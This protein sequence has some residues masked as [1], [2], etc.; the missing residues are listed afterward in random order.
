[1]LNKNLLNKWTVMNWGIQ[2]H[3]HL[4]GRGCPL[5]L[6]LLIVILV[7]LLLFLFASLS[8]WSPF[9]SYVLTYPYASV[10]LFPTPF[11]SSQRENL[12]W[13]ISYHPEWYINL[14]GF[15]RKV[16]SWTTGTIRWLPLT[17]AWFL[18]QL[19]SDQDGSIVGN[20]LGNVN[21]RIWRWLSSFRDVSWLDQ[22]IY[23]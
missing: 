23:S 17:R 4:L 16:I 15:L 10:F 5:N 21:R 18:Q 20:K 11:P 13:K 12:I 3:C 19:L 8:A 2:L 14:A 9:H 22:N 7:T 6:V 1:M